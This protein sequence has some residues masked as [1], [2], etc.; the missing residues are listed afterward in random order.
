MPD[1]VSPAPDVR[2]PGKSF[3]SAAYFDLPY[4]SKSAAQ[5]LDIYLPARGSRPYPVIVWMHPGGFHIGD[6]RWEIADNAEPMLSRGYAVV[7]INYRL[8]GEAIFP[9]QIYDAKAAICW[10]RAH[11]AEH[12]F[13][14]R[15]IV[16]AGVSAG[17]Y[18]A[19]MLGTTGG[20]REMEDLSLGHAEQSSMVNAVVDLYGPL[21]FLRK[22]AQLIELG[23]EPG[24]SDA[25]APEAWLLGC[26]LE[27]SPQKCAQANPTTY[28]SK[29]SPPFY[30]Q[31][32]TEDKHIPYLQSKELADCLKAAIG[33][34]KV[35]LELV[36]GA[37]HFDAVHRSSRS[38][39][40]ILDFLDRQLA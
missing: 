34:D 20:V 21:D 32:G 13:D 23:L 35:H 9:A 15:R 25:D 6:K 24:P 10:I 5:K 28:I 27:E 39:E 38:I 3:I 18:L 17:G 8:S 11:A 16:A 22:N 19:A 26:V 33:E 40:K 29:S 1:A 36:P 2:A 30:I 4:A 37:H 31:H 7:S 14:P 12:G